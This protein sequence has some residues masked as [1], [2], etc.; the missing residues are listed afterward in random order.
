MSTRYIDPLNTAHTASP[1]SIRYP[2]GRTASLPANLSPEEWPDIPGCS[3]E[4]VPEPDPV[5]RVIPDEARAV[6]GRIALA[7]A[8]TGIDGVPADVP[9]AIVKAKAKE[10]TLETLQAQVDLVTQLL[11]VMVQLRDLDQTGGIWADVQTVAAGG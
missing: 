8:A 9:D 11:E 1:R 2:D 4:D 10:V 7:W 5:P 3:V 6:A